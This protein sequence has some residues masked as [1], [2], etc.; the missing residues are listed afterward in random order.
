MEKKATQFIILSLH[1]LAISSNK[2]ICFIVELYS[3]TLL[4][5]T[6]QFS[7]FLNQASS[8]LV[9]LIYRPKGMQGWQWAF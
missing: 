1:T 2:Q 4:E 9:C 7:L 3:F 6:C 8:Q 5:I